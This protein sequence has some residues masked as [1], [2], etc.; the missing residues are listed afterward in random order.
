MNHAIKRAILLNCAGLLAFSQSPEATPKF[1]IADVHV[2]AKA[3]NPF[4]RIPPVRAGRY[5]LKNAT[6]VDLVRI[7][8]SFDADKVLGGPSWLEMDRFDVR[9]KVPADSTPEMHK[10][11][12]QALL[13][14]R[15]HL[16]VHKETKPLPGYALTAG[17]KP[18][19]REAEGTEDAGCRPQAASG[20]P[21]EGGMRIMMMSENGAPTTISLGPGMTIH[22]LCRN[23]TMAAFAAGL[24]NMM[25]A[26]LGVNPV[27]EETGLKGAWNFDVK[28][29]MR[30]IGLPGTES[31]DQVSMFEA[32]EKQLGLKLEPRQI[33]TPVII[34]DRVNEKPADNPPGVAEALPV[35]PM[36][37]EF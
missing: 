15:F 3:T 1:E 5:E 21:S 11:M 19:L 2:A 24:R 13:E 12:L 27:L 28:W 31:G 26:S 29:S 23:M 4:V 30:F 6:M 7:A 16:V 32:V 20:A 8:Y 18:Q 9:A 37:T 34:V 35:T 25:G 33:P 17:K 36:P 10:Q 22:Y 14:D